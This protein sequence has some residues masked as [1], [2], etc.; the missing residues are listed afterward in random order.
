VPRADIRDALQPI[1]A[2]PGIVLPGKRTFD[3]VFDLSVGE[4]GLSFAGCYHLTLAKRLRM[5]TILS[6]DRILGRVSATTRAESYSPRA[7]RLVY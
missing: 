1:L 3:E 7:C 6:F 2:L 5:G 4:A